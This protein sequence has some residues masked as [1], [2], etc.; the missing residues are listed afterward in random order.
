[1][2]AINAT[3]VDRLKEISPNF[4]FI[5]STIVA[6]RTGAG[7][8]YDCASHWDIRTDGVVTSKFEN[9]TIIAIITVFTIA[10]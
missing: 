5:S 9:D 2:E 6:Q 1:M 10:I 4:K 8:H 7:L 3:C